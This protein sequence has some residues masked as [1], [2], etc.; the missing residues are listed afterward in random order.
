MDIRLSL[1]LHYIALATS[2]WPAPH[3]VF[4]HHPTGKML[5]QAHG[6]WPHHFG[7]WFHHILQTIK[8]LDSTWMRSGINLDWIQGWFN[9]VLQNFSLH[10][11]SSYFF[12]FLV[13]VFGAAFFFPQIQIASLFLNSSHPP[14]IPKLSFLCLLNVSSLA[15]L[16]FL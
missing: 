9:K 10:S 5:P 13:F 11:F 16:I 6:L 7:L 3:S 1:S 4:P 12:T 15:V 8:G 2:V 14:Y